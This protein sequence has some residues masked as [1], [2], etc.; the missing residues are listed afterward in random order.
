MNGLLDWVKTP[1]GQGLLAAAFSGMA[2]ARKG[3]PINTLGAAG[4]GGLLGYDKAL[5][6]QAEAERDKAAAVFRGLQ[7]KVVQQQFDQADAAAK[8]RTN[9]RATLTP[10]QQV[11]FDANPE[12]FMGTMDQFRKPEKQTIPWYV[13]KDPVTGQISIDPAYAD[14]EKTKA[15]AGAARSPANPY[16]TPIPTVNGLGRFDNRSG[17]FELLPGG[18]TKPTDDPTR[19]GAITGA[20]E[21]A[22]AAS[23]AAADARKAVKKSDQLLSV[24]QEAESLL[25]LNPTGSGIGAAMDTAGRWIGQSST[26]SQ[27]ASKLETLSGWLTANVPRMEGPQSNFDVT[28]YQTMAAKVGDRTVPVVERQAALKTLVALQEKYK[29]LNQGALDEPAVPTAAPA[30]PNPGRRNTDKPGGVMKFDAQGNPI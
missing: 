3:A 15:A 24:A 7:G 26:S 25:A 8:G 28:A 27:V 4:M 29:H 2:G 19:Q 17:T 30:A 22:K 5:D 16:Y 9:L 20:K 6:T 12:G 13:K 10:E 1:E 21:D 11:A 14:F 23:E 18:I